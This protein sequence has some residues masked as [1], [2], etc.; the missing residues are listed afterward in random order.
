MQKSNINKLY[1]EV[2]KILSKSYGLLHETKVNF[3]F[4]ETCGVKKKTKSCDLFTLVTVI[5]HGDMS[6]T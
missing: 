4:L 5:C 1:V 2:K 3:V 6:R